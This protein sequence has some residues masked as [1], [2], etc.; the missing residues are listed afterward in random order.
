MIAVSNAF[1]A[2]MDLR[3]DFR[4]SAHITFADGAEID[5]TDE[6]FAISGNAITD[7]ASTDGLP[8]GVAVEI[9]MIVE[10]DPTLC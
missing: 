2:A 5:L 3:R 7:G 4:C 10:I 1:L 8:L 9:N 6:D